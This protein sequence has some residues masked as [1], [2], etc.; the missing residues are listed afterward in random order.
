[1]KTKGKRRVIKAKA[2]KKAPP[3]KFL[4]CKCGTSIEVNGEATSVQCPDC[5]V[6]EQLE[7]FGWPKGSK[8]K[9]KEEAAIAKIKRPAGWHF[10]NEYVDELGNVFHKGVEQLELFGTLPPTKIKP[11][12]K[13]NRKTKK[14][15][16]REKSQGYARVSQE[17]REVTGKID[18]VLAAGKKH[19]IKKLEKELKK[20]RKEL[21]KYL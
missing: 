17:V 7:K 21:S 9:T 8:K 15:S 12:V 13:S 2:E 5:T 6:K 14:L 16:K 20:K 3:Y 1:V 19:G 10:M 4:A 18:K 11:K